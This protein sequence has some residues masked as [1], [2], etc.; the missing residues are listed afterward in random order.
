[1]ARSIRPTAYGNS[2]H[3]TPE[4]RGSST[5][6]QTDVAYPCGTLSAVAC[7][8]AWPLDQPRDGG[9]KQRFQVHAFAGSTPAPSVEGKQYRPGDGL[10][11]QIAMSQPERDEGWPGECLV[12]SMQP[13]AI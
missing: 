12:M 2:P 7:P 9:D 3:D 6:G 4:R 11:R 10:R 5:E 8:E 13:K 1:M